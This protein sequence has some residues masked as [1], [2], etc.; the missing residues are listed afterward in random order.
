MTKYTLDATNKKIGR[1]A[2]EAASLLMGKNTTVYARNVVPAV[3]VEIINASK[4]TIPASKLEQKKYTTY[5]GYPGGLKETAMKRMIERKGHSELFRIAV[6]GMLPINKLRS[7]M[8]KNLK[9][10]E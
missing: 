2:S 7:R 9:I 6:Y 1:L 10:S 8:I 3:E 5:S 4:A